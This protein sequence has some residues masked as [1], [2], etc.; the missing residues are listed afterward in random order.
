MLARA[1]DAAVEFILMIFFNSNSR[2]KLDVMG[3]S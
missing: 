3:N 1:E 2:T